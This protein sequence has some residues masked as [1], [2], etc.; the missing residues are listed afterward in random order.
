MVIYVQHY[1]ESEPALRHMFNKYKIPR[2][3]ILILGR[4]YP[5][6]SVALHFEGR[7]AGGVS[8]CNTS[9]DAYHAKI[10]FT[11]ALRRACKLWNQNFN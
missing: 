2:D 10:G 8:I 11:I 4:A 7:T 5:A 9:K 6:T 3:A 1:I